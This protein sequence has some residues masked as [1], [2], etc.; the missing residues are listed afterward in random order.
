[1]RG[2]WSIWNISTFSFN[3]DRQ[4][5]PTCGPRIEIRKIEATL[6]GKLSLEHSFI[7]FCSKSVFERTSFSFSLSGSESSVH[8]KVNSEVL[9]II[10]ALLNFHALK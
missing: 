5:L 10:L 8:D 7:L 2:N 6:T 1:M 4:T 3:Q 9:I